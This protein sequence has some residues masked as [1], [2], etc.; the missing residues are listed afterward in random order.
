LELT[1]SKRKHTARRETNGRIQ[2]EARTTPVANA[3][4]IRDEAVRTSA[5]AEYGTELGRLYLDDKISTSMYEAGKRWAIMANSVATAMQGPSANPKSLA[6]GES[7]TSHPVD[8]GSEEG[9]REVKRHQHAV[10]AFQTAGDKLV[11][12]T[13]RAVETVCEHGLACDGFVQ[14]MDLRSGLAI[15]AGHWHMTG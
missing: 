11:G 14:L 2:R 3:K 6:I 7:G 4:R 10:Q 5:H 13:R 8:P 15:L 1:M 9:E 12:G